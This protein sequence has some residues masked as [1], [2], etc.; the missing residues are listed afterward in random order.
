MCVYLPRWKIGFIP[1]DFYFTVL[2]ESECYENTRIYLIKLMSLQ[3]F[4]IDISIYNISV[5]VGKW[6]FSNRFILSFY[7]NCICSFASKTIES[8]TTKFYYSLNLSNPFFHDSD[9]LLCLF[10]CIYRAY[11]RMKL[12]LCYKCL[13]THTL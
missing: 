1:T 12:P 6:W 4:L 8:K 5:G 3:V 10:H 2:S 13:F 7:R 11:T 9:G